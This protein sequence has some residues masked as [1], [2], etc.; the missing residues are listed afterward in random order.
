MMASSMVHRCA[1]D[2]LGFL[3]GI[4]SNPLHPNL[5]SNS[6]ELLDR[7]WAIDVTRDGQ[8][9]LLFLFL[10]K[11]GKFSNGGG[12]TCALAQR[13]KTHERNLST[14]STPLPEN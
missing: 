9:F 14:I 13:S 3:S 1:G 10:K 12:F 2:V 4:G 11:F 5:G 6:L 7:S 8:Y